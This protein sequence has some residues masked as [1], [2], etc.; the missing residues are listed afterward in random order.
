MYL[1]IKAKDIINDK[2]LPLSNEQYWKLRKAFEKY[3]VVQ[4]LDIN[5]SFHPNYYD[6]DETEEH[7]VTWLAMH[8]YI[9]PLIQQLVANQKVVE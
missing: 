8:A 7:W 2:T 5:R 4:D 6:S 3:A 1:T 9:Q